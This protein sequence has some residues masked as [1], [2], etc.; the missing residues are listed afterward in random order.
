[1]W[2]L[3]SETTRPYDKRF[4]DELP[5][6]STSSAQAIV[7]WIVELIHPDSIIDV[8]CGL[9]CWL[10]VFHQQGV[11]DFLGV[12]GNWVPIDQMQIPAD[13][14]QKWDLKKPYKTERQ[15]ALA[16]SLE[17]AEHLPATYASDFVRSLTALAPVILFSAAVPS[18]G[19]IGHLNEQWPAYW[20][21][22]FEQQGYETVDCVR[23]CFWNDPRV[24][25]WYKQN[26]LFFVRIDCLSHYQSLLRA[27]KDYSIGNLSIIHPGQYFRRIKELEDPRS[28]SLKKLAQVAPI[29]IGR[30]VNYRLGRIF[31][32]M[33]G[34]GKSNS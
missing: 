16:I 1:M 12:D 6:T 3:I 14:F 10:S 30:S 24:A 31:S 11:E 32:W 8:G 18:Q 4:F 20:I 22:L 9:G 29:L 13:R 26:A 15:F 19:G 33:R 7:P 17:V 21:R 27:R 23:G 25:P 34:N 5:D 28:Y 2:H